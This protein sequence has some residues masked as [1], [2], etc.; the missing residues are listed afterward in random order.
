VVVAQPGAWW[1]GCVMAM[2]VATL[3][4]C[5]ARSSESHAPAPL[6]RPSTETIELH[7]K[8]F[9]LH[10]SEPTRPA[11]SD[12][13]VL[14][15]SGD[16][17]WFGAAVD[18]FHRIADAGYYAVGFSSRAFLRIQRP[19]AALD[20]RQLASEYD[21]IL[22]EARRALHLGA[23]TRAILTGWSRGAA[24]A[25]IVGSEPVEGRALRGIVAIGLSDGEDLQ[26]NG[27][28]D[29][30]DEEGGKS[31]HSR[32]WPYEPYAQL[33]HLARLPCAVIQATHDGYLPAA[34]AHALFGP[35]T[36][37]RRFY[38]VQAK[39][40]RF[41]GG[42]EAFNRALVDSIGWIVSTSRTEQ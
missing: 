30:T 28:D 34:R 3:P 25:V 21:Q 42:K 7:G 24:F 19:R 31:V 29:E 4:G 41:G 18:M 35:D 26:V 36:A 40:H 1:K 37:L 16:G 11:A 12:T 17:G 39:N 38:E 13:L 33:A 9:E 10:L 5:A 14:Y 20:A 6:A 22:V 8:P 15:A 2:F 32:R 23:A 27:S